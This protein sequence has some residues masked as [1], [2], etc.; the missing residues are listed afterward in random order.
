EGLQRRPCAPGA[1]DGPCGSRTGGSE[2]RRPRG[3]RCR[4]P[5]DPRRP[6][7]PS[8]RAGARGHAAALTPYLWSYDVMGRDV[9]TW[10]SAVQDRGYRRSPSRRFVLARGSPRCRR[11][12]AVPA[13]RAF[14][15]AVELAALTGSQLVALAGEGPLPAHA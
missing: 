7:P 3:G 5:V 6:G 4:L 15:K 14:E 9:T 12:Q 2:R 13:D 11:A 1:R 8:R 10:L